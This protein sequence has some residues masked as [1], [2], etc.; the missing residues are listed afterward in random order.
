MGTFFP[1]GVPQGLALRP[2]V[3]RPARALPHR[4]TCLTLAELSHAAEFSP[5][6]PQTATP[7]VVKDIC[8]DDTGFNIDLD[9]G[10]F[11]TGS[12]RPN[13][14]LTIKPTSNLAS[15]VALLIPFL[16]S[17]GAGGSIV[18]ATTQSD[19]E[20]VVA[21]LKGKIEARFYHAGV[22]ADER[23]ATQEWFMA[24]QGVVV[25]TIAFGMGLDKADVRQVVHFMLP[26]TLEN[27][28]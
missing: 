27:Y 4:R 13:L 20:R 19:A 9:K 23:K 1:P 24:S 28:S 14:H 18:Y 21:A 6:A 7:S 2:R 26:K 8:N 15:K 12:Y 3:Q 16:Q 11:S 5:S 17:R 10:V 22:S 25:A